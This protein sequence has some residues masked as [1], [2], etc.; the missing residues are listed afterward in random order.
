[1]TVVDTASLLKT[2]AASFAAGVGVTLVFS[3]AIYGATRFA[4]FGRE[5][6]RF[7]AFV[8]GSVALLALAACAAVVVLAI[9]VMTS[10]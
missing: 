6:R 3:V 9:V 7:A 5:D 1:A 4:D 2:V 10:K 8:A